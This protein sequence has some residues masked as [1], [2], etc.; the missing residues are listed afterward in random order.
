[1]QSTRLVAFCDLQ[2][3]RAVEQAAKYPAAVYTDYRE[4]LDKETLNAVYRL[5]PSNTRGDQEI[6]AAERGLHLFVEK[7][8]NFDLEQ[9]L[10]NRRPSKKPA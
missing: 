4:M 9:T 10:Q 6:M 1:M 7:P 8:L 5:T 2:R 3:E